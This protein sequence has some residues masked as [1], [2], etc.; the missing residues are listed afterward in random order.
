MNKITD[1]IAQRTKGK[2]FKTNK[3]SLDNNPAPGIRYDAESYQAVP[4]RY[5]E[6]TRHIQPVDI[7]KMVRKLQHYPPLFKYFLDGSR[8]TYRVDDIIYEQK[9]FPIIAGQIGVG[10]CW[11]EDRSL[12]GKNPEIHNVI[13]LP[14]AADKDGGFRNNFFEKLRAELCD[15]DVLKKRG[16]SFSKVLYYEETLKENEN[17]EHKGIA[18]IQDAMIENEKK[19]VSELVKTNFLDQKNYLLKDGSLEY[20]NTKQG[21]D[22]EWI[23]IKNN[24]HFCIGASKTFNPEKFLDFKNRSNASMIANLKLYHRTPVYLYESNITGGVPFGVWYVRIRG[25]CYSSSPFDG[26]LK[27]EKVLVTNKEKEEGMESD[28]VDTITAHIINER[29]PV[30]YGSDNRWINHI[31]PIYLTEQFIKSKYL[32][33]EYFLNLF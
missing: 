25:G 8:M 10:Y 26:I 21:D 27:L 33:S 20:K 30:C 1:F 22:K 16:V 19:I 17:Y 9:V 6:T 12:K 18:K 23:K 11:R 2:S 7:S 5:G 13:V 24:Y 4:T 29:N 14:A 28:L 15:I 3:Y 32:S 31:Y